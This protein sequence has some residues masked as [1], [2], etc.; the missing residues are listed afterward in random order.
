MTN[1][2]LWKAVRSGWAAALAR[3]ALLG[4]TAIGCVAIPGRAAGAAEETLR[5]TPPPGWRQV[6]AVE[7][8][9]L[10]VRHLIPPGQGGDDWRDMIT[11]QVL[12]TAL[13]PPLAGLYARA[14]AGYQAQCPD[15]R[16][17]GLQQGE[18]NGYATGFWVLGC[19]ENTQTGRGETAFFKATLGEQ[20]VYV[21]Q[22]VWRTAPFEPGTEADI[23]ADSR[24]Q[25]I[26][27]LK[28]AQVCLSG[29]T[30]HPCR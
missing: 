21:M 16:G 25:A 20:A 2:R 10:I 22:R 6:H 3:G 12:R 5:F 9:G 15:A 1:E 27:M 13:P 17:G 11:V 8:D 30:A 14:L 7:R 19:P 26:D 4:L 23:D 24:R 29:S 28:A 18:S